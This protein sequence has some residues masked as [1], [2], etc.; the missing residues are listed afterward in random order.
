MRKRNFIFDFDGTIA[1]TNYIVYEILNSLADEF[2]F[3]KIL[4]KDMK[5][6]RNKTTK[7]VFVYMGISAWKL[8][9]VIKRVL[10]TM[11]KR[12]DSIEPIL[13]IREAVREMNRKNV[14]VGIITSNNKENVK[15]FL[16]NNDLDIFDFIYTGSSI[17]GK[18]RVLRK[19]LKDEKLDPQ[20]TYY[21]GDE[22]R[23]IDAAR[24]VGIKSIAVTW[25]FQ[26]EAILRKQK[27]DYV[28]VSPYELKAGP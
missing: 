18:A 23:D 24:A 20:Q 6:L 4:K 11:F 7:E 19:V 10:N 13:G 1:D 9:F 27:P 15:R 3:K 5:T 8:P 14:R 22:T 16:R 17:F 26:G 28:I 2:H 25:G 21:I 12:I